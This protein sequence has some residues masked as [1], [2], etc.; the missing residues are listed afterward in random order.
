MAEVDKC[1]RVCYKGNTMNTKRGVGV[2]FQCQFLTPDKLCQWLFD[3]VGEPNTRITDG[4]LV[5]TDKEWYFTF[6]AQA[7]VLRIALWT[8]LE[9]EAARERIQ[10]RAKTIARECECNLTTWAVDLYEYDE[11]LKAHV[12]KY[13]AM[14]AG[15]LQVTVVKPDALGDAPTKKTR[16]N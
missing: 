3:K 5:A 11:K 15:E 14:V 2:K 16:W 7:N 1:S 12:L 6:S 13:D 4:S 10:E 8:E 9:P